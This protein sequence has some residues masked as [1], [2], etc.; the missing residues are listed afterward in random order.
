[1]SWGQMPVSWLIS[2]EDE[3]QEGKYD[4]M[5]PHEAR[6]RVREAYFWTRSPLIDAGQSTPGW[7]SSSK[8]YSWHVRGQTEAF[9]AFL[10]P[11]L[12]L[13]AR[14]LKC[15]QNATFEQ[16]IMIIGRRG[17]EEG[18][19]LKS[20]RNRPYPL[21][22]YCGMAMMQ[23]RLYFCWQYFSW[24]QTKNGMLNEWWLYA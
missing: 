9:L 10:A 16:I 13:T 7:R 18:N 12:L 22:W 17:E 3:S 15:K 19:S 5:T 2:I 20:M 8:H 21:R 11:L 1:M 23:D 4:L 14:N 24:I 6:E